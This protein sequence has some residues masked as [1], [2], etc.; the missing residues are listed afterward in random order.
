[1]SE[2]EV[3][4]HDADMS[5]KQHR[6]LSMK[7][8]KGLLPKR[9][10]NWYQWMP[11]VNVVYDLLFD[12]APTVSSL[13]KTLNV[14]AIVDA[15]LLTV[16]IAIPGAFDYEGKE[17]VLRVSSR[18]TIACGRVSVIKRNATCEEVDC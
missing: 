15:L 8:S 2:S 1:M 5:T 7:S 14:I 3:E 13:E 16:V 9:F 6:M 11:F 17:C 4:W 10:R 18:H 12:E